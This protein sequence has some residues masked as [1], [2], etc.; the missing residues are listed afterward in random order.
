MR[1]YSNLQNNIHT[2]NDLNIYIYC[3]LVLLWTLSNDF[4]LKQK[5]NICAPLP[6]ND[7]RC[8]WDTIMQPGTNKSIILFS[9]KPP[10]SKLK[11]DPLDIPT[12]TTIKYIWTIPRPIEFYHVFVAQIT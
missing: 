3:I 8:A 9:T 10:Y 4:Y 11:Y 2:A 7:A 6:L 1:Y 5:I 12:L